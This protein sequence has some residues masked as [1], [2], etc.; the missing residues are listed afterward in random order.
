MRVVGADSRAA[1]GPRTMLDNGVGPAQL[2]M[3]YDHRQC[4]WSS[5]VGILKMLKQ[6]PVLTGRWCFRS[7]P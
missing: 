3:E 4:G 7:K 2:A 1:F 6:V 5:V